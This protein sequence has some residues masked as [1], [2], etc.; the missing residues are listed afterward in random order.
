MSWEFDLPRFESH[1][2]VARSHKRSEN[3]RR[4]RDV[5]FESVARP[6]TFKDVSKS[7]R[8]AEEPKPEIPETNSPQKKEKLRRHGLKMNSDDEGSGGESDASLSSSS[9]SSSS[10]SSTDAAPESSQAE[11]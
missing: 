5:V 8:D 11:K 1:F 4:R 9:S 3:Q 10:T 6:P 2:S 7:M